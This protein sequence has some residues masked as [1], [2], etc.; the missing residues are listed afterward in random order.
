MRNLFPSNT[1]V[2]PQLGPSSRLVVA[3]A[4]GES[5]ALEGR[6]L[7]GDS[8]NWFNALYGKAGVKRDD[9]NIINTIQCRPLNNVYPT[10]PDATYISKADARK[11]VDH[12][13]KNHVE[14]MLKSR[15][16][17]RVDLLGD[18][19]LN[20]V[21]GKDGI[22]K[23]RGSPMPV[24]SI[25]PVVPIAIPTLHP[26]AIMRDQ[27]MMPVV[28][29]DLRKSLV[30]PP[31]RYNLFPSIEDVK[32][33]TATE[34]AFDLETTYEGHPWEDCK[35]IKMVGLS[36]ENCTA[37]VVPFRGA[38]IDELRRI[39]T[40]AKVLV[41]HNLIQFDIPILFKALGLEWSA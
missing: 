5:E 36:A 21:T 30:V 23:W 32:K 7:C 27:S 33:F 24:P 10:D 22:Y 26:A 11:A 4:P 25:D 34:F 39:F 37:L 12:C 14:P 38:Y 35:K 28:V 41:G 29:N 20:A 6:P 9:L 17:S 16:W 19:A 40:N 13:F 18:K 31:E 3:E 8:G 15:A 2:S 1:F